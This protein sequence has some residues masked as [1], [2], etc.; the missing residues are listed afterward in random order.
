MHKSSNLKKARI[1][2]ILQTDVAAVNIDGT[3]IHSGLGINVG[4]KTFPLNNPQFA[5]LRNK[6][7]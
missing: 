6:L 3:T 4:S 2:L 7:S 1:L 5:I